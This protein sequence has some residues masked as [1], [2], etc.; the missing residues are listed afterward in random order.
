M[1]IYSLIITGLT[2]VLSF[3]SCK[4]DV[5]T[6]ETNNTQNK[7]EIYVTYPSKMVMTK[8]TTS[9]FELNW[10]N[11]DD[12]QTANI[13]QPIPLPWSSKITDANIDIN[14]AR[15]IKKE[16]GWTFLFH[17]FDDA[18]DGADTRNYMGF[19]NQRT[20]IMKIF[21][22]QKDFIPDFITIL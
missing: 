7:N 5:F 14:V 1:K 18:N 6:N 12:V 15:D 8:G 21:Y 9:E 16:D 2:I 13:K 20:G 11:Q 17:T 22:Y 19:Y 4:E 3:S 10:E